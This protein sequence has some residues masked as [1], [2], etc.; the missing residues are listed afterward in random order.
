ML[1]NML[2]YEYKTAKLIHSSH[3]VSLG[4]ALAIA[5]LGFQPFT[6]QAVSFVQRLTPSGAA[7]ISSCSNITEYLIGG[8][9]LSAAPSKGFKLNHT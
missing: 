4:A 6:Q 9:R 2:S 3:L 8:T 1:G 5:A 7:T